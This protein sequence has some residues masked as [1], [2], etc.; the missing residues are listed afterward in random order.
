MAGMPRN[1]KRSVDMAIVGPSRRGQL[2]LLDWSTLGVTAVVNLVGLFAGFL[3]MLVRW[4]MAYEPG[5]YG[6][7]FDTVADWGTVGAGATIFTQ[8]AIDTL[9]RLRYGWPPSA[10]H[11]NAILW[12]AVIQ[13]ATAAVIYGPDYLAGMNFGPY[14]PVVAMLL[15]FTLQVLTLWLKENKPNYL[16][17]E[18][19]TLDPNELPVFQQRPDLYQNWPKAVLLVALL[20]AGSQAAGPKAVVS[21]PKQAR[22]GDVV[23]LDAS[24][25]TGAT[26]FNWRP[27]GNAAAVPLQDGKHCAVST[28]RGQ[29]TFMLIVSNAE[30]NDVAFYTLQ[31]EHG[32][33]APAPVPGPVPT[34]TPVPTPIPTPP[35]A[36]APEPTFP[37]GTFGL[38]QLTYDLARKVPTAGRQAETAALADALDQLRVDCETGSLKEAAATAIIQRFS[39]VTKQALGSAHQAWLGVFGNE[40]SKQ[41]SAL[42]WKGKLNTPAQWAEL[43]NEIV[44]PLREAAKR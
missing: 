15:P 12:N 23:I 6:D 33:P 11:R 39:E 40:L 38:A 13:I 17:D 25:S 20:A 27:M 10:E 43:L 36:P 2:N 8:F 44:P 21:G 7:T 24:Q 19:E 31:V 22:A 30:G 28:Y 26:H 42:Y 41:I 34:P 35:P 16:P 37:P 3:A 29:S 5:L 4:R 1:F 18:P 14:A 32:D 9:S